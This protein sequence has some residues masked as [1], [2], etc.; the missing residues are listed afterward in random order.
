MAGSAQADGLLFQHT[1]PRSVEA[2]D[3]TTGGQY[4]APPIPYGHYAKDYIDD[5]D[6][7]L[8]CVSCRLHA[9]FGGAGAGHGLFHHGDGNYGDGSGCGH[10]HGFGHGAG[11]CGAAGH[12]CGSGILGHGGG[13][14]CG[15]A[16]GGGGSGYACTQTTP[17]GQA[18]VYSSAQSSCAQPGCKIRSRHFHG[19]GANSGPCGI[20]GGADPGCGSGH[21]HGH[22]FGH[23]TGCPIC[24]G[25]GCKHCL[26]SAL[27]GLHGLIG[28]VHGSLASLA[29]GLN[30]PKT[31]WF[32]GPGGPVPLTPG[33]VPY[34][35]VTRS[36]RDY[37]AFPPR[38]PNDP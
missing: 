38:N 34:I 23:G 14:S 36:P 37:F 13:L 29:A 21:G 20:C 18:A 11:A 12:G 1:I 35:V 9:H 26:G 2:Y 4:Y 17:S 15:V 27:G 16:G 6:K 24:G 25:T 10:N 31:S 5:L 22:G 3:Y 8:G 19:G 33:Y 7:A 30:A 32:L 28:H